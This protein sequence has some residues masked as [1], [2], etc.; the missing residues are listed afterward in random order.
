M[1]EKKTSK[2][3]VREFKLHTEQIQKGSTTIQKTLV[4]RKGITKAIWQQVWHW[5]TWQENRYR[6]LFRFLIGTGADHGAHRQS[7]KEKKR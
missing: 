7:L 1:K 6:L 4:G 3:R 2:I 5:M